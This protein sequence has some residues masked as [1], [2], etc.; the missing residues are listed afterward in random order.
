M[1]I[2]AVLTDD[3]HL[4]PTLEDARKR[5]PMEKARAILRRR[6]RQMTKE[7]AQRQDA[8]F[9]SALQERTQTIGVQNVSGL[10]LGQA[11]E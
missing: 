9:F 11:G 8:M 6:T 10:T 3:T 4:V 1:Y 5:R 2:P 7:E